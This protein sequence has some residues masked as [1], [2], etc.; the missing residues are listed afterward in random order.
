MK[1]IILLFLLLP[2]FLFAQTDGT[3]TADAVT[4]KINPG[5][6]KVVKFTFAL[7]S[8]GTL[9]SS[10]WAVHE[11][12]DFL[13]STETLQAAYKL[14]STAGSPKISCYIHASMDNINFI[15]ID[16]LFSDITSETMAFVSTDMNSI[17]APYLKLSLLGVAAGRD[18]QVGW[19]HIYHYQKKE[20]E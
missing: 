20:T 8:S 16:T 17:H 9:T 3:W 18:D 14:T 5:Q 12:D 1:R 4:T 10:S 11:E 6:G 15:V 19:I 13:W 2:M 7:D